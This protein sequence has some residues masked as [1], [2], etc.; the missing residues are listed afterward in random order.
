MIGRRECIFAGGEVDGVLFILLFYVVL[1]DVVLLKYWV[2]SLIKGD[3]DK[4]IRDRVHVQTTE[5]NNK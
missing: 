3:K 5:V 1:A 2:D 4:K